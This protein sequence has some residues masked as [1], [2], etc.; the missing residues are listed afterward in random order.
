MTDQTETLEETI[1]HLLA[2]G[3]I[4]KIGD[5]YYVTGK[6]ADWETDPTTNPMSVT[7]RDYGTA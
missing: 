2:E 6:V 7:G 5:R 3:L 4:V 1:E